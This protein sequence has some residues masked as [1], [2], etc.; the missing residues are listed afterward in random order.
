[1]VANA[2]W[3]ASGFP[4]APVPGGGV[5]KC[6]S[7]SATPKNIRPMPM[8]AENIMAI[9]ETPLNSGSSSSR[10]SGIVP[11]RPSA[12]QSTKTT[13]PDPV[14]TNN[15]PVLSMTHVSALPEALASDGVL[16]KPHTRNPTAMTAVMPN[17]T[18]STPRERV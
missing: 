9:Q 13:N 3:T 12:S 18:Q 6:V 7:G 15:Q 4:A 2:F 1:M 17:T 10:P 16:T 5:V 11:Y 8:P 14:S